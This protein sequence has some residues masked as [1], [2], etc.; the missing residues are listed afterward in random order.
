MRPR[1][2]ID[3]LWT[4]A[5]AVLLLA[6]P[7][8]S[9]N[10]RLADN[11]PSEQGADYRSSEH[12]LTP[13]VLLASHE[14]QD[15][16]TPA[17]AFGDG[18][19][20]VAWQS[21][22]IAQGDLCSNG[23][24]FIADIVAARLDK[25]GKE[26]D[27]EPFVVSGAPD[28][29][30]RPAI[31]FGGGV[32]LVVWQDLRNGRD[33]DVRAARVGPDGQV[34]DPDGILVAGQARSQG[35]PR[36]AWDGKTFVVAWMDNSAGRYRVVAARLSPEGSVLD[37]EGIVVS[38]RDG[39][40]SIFPAIASRGDGESALFW[41]MSEFGYGGKYWAGGA[42]VSDGQ[43]QPLFEWT[44]KEW[45]ATGRKLGP[46]KHS[47]PLAAAASS[48]GYLL[49]WSNRGS[50]NKPSNYSLFGPDGQRGT[51]LLTLSGQEQNLIAP[52]AA[53]DGSRLIAA[54]TTQE[55]PG[56]DQSRLHDRVHASRLAADGRPS[57]VVHS[58]AGAPETPAKAAAI[59]S[60][61]AGGACI[62]YESHPADA[63]TPI[64]IGF[65]LLSPGDK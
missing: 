9:C 37:P 28:L 14:G 30:E 29:Q 22:R 27:P 46:D 60:D 50:G 52:V 20:L 41:L 31:A 45:D 17:V 32:F 1:A 57:K 49:A 36:V 6:N 7:S 19:Y 5:L 40:D 24:D 2:T 12:R 62:V 63:Q 53:W 48:S 13:G 10:G 65:R 25:T 58:I 23:P 16:Y 3:P 51:D 61:G 33:W 39:V 47:S 44:Q 35:A 11:G 56:K 59:A 8:C 18:T 54:W 26:L 34:L 42:L 43:A 55:A 4:A 15:A 38:V 64:A 21:G